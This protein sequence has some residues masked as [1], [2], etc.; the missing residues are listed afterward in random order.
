MKNRFYNI[1]TELQQY[2][3]RQQERGAQVRKNRDST[4]AESKT[5]IE[6]CDQMSEVVVGDDEFVLDILEFFFKERLS[7]SQ[8]NADLRTIAAKMLWTARE[9][10]GTMDLIPRPPKGSPSPKWLVQQAVQIAFRKL[11]NQCKIYEAVR[12]TATLKWKSAYNIAKQG[13]VVGLTYRNSSSLVSNHHSVAQSNKIDYH[14]PGA[15]DARKQPSGMTCWATVYTMLESWRRQQSISIETA[16]GDLGGKW[17][18]MFKNNKGL[19]AADKKVFVKAT[20]LLDYEPFNPSIEGW[21]DMLKEFGPI[22]VTTNENPGGTWAIHA[23]V[24]IGIKGDGT[25]KGTSFTIIDPASGRKYSETIETFWP[26]FEDEMF[27]TNRG[28]IQILHWAAN[29]QSLSLANGLQDEA[30]YLNQNARSYSFQY[31]FN[32]TNSVGNGGFNRPKDVEA[33]KKRLHTL[34]YNWIKLNS[35]M[36][37]ETIRVI[38]LF[39]SITKGYQSMKGDGL[40]DVKTKKIPTYLWLRAKN[41]PRWQ[42][43][44][45]S[46]TG[47]KDSDDK[48]YNKRDGYV[49]MNWGTDWLIDTIKLAGMEYEKNYRKGDAKKALIHTNDLSLHKGGDTKDH[50]GHETGLLVDVRLPKKD[51]SADGG[52]TW[53]S[54][55][56][57]RAAARAMIKAFRA[58]PLFDICYFNDTTL[59]D[60]GLC[61]KADAHNDHFHITIK[62]PAIEHDLKI[63]PQ[64]SGGVRTGTYGAKVEM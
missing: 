37:V 54:S 14:I 20:G 33:L 35:K 52:I 16:L 45:A 56:Y 19:S 23:R 55:S 48:A 13:I 28:R 59:I 32:L 47:Y 41:A 58:Q 10:S 46:G 53:K 44:P 27:R 60:E 29:A 36:D 38:Q 50:Q 18:S 40:V 62:P 31:T 64:P 11:N 3:L 22:W 49:L 1:S 9:A 34:G 42:Q 17:L 7:A 8:L 63:I 5:K 61:K 6:K 30:Q 24:I 12:K 4:L 2:K 26:K 15:I 39:Q 25:S 21:R 57:D 51:G 43:M